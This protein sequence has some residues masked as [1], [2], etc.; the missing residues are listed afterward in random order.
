MTSRG[1]L[2]PVMAAGSAICVVTAAASGLQS[3][4]PRALAT[5]LNLKS[6]LGLPVVIAGIRYQARYVRIEARR[7]GDYALIFRLQR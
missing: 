6:G 1:I 7:D 5:A 2:F 3:P 4:S